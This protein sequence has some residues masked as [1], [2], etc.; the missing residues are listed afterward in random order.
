MRHTTL[1]IPTQCAVGKNHVV[2]VSVDVDGVIQRIACDCRPTDPEIVIMRAIGEKTCLDRVAYIHALRTGTNYLYESDIKQAWPEASALTGAL[3]TWLRTARS[4]HYARTTQPRPA[5][6]RLGRMGG[7]LRRAVP[8]TA[9]TGREIVAWDLTA[10]RSRSDPTIYA[11]LEV[12]YTVIAYLHRADSRSPTY[13]VL[14]ANRAEPAPS[15]ARKNADRRVCRLCSADD[16]TAHRTGLRHLAK[17]VSLARTMLGRLNI[18][19]RAENDVL[20]E[21][22]HAT[23]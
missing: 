4:T 1:R 22:N 7:I 16:T 10:S 18:E 9:D 11:Q 5:P 14:A 3:A 13:A 15:R 8:R 23:Y 17:V 2:H 20:T 19:L 21:V 6:D 12:R